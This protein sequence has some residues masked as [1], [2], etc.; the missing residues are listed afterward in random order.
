MVFIGMPG[1]PGKDAQEGT[2]RQ[3]LETVVDRDLCIGCGA[4]TAL[5]DSPFEVRMCDDG[6]F[7][8]APRP[9]A[10]LDHPGGYL[11]VCPFAS[12]YDEDQLAAVFVDASGG[13]PHPEVGS[14]RMISAGHV[15]AGTFRK[16]GSSGGMTTW[17]LDRLLDEGLVD[18][19]IHV[20]NHGPETLF[21]Y[22]VSSTREE[23]RRGAKTRY[24]PVEM[25]GVLDHVRRTEGRYAVV[26]LPCFIK[27]VRLLQ[28]EDEV[29][30]E[31]VAFAVGIFCGH[32]KST[33]FADAL[34]WQQGVA[35]GDLRAIDFRQK[36]DE[37]ALAYAVATQ[38][39]RG[40][41]RSMLN[42]RH[43]PSDWGM[44]MFRYRA[45]D[46][47]DDVLNETADVAFGDAWLPGFDEDPQG[48]NVM[49]V[50]SPEALALVA[51]RHEELE[52]SPLSADDAARSQAAGLRH[53][54]EG[55]AYRLFLA[56]SRGEW[57]PRKRVSPSADLEE[58]RRRIYDLRT[59]MLT[60]AD[61]A[62]EQGLAQGSFRAFR[63][64]VMPA[65]Q[66]YLRAYER[67]PR[68]RARGVIKRRIPWLKSARGTARAARNVLRRH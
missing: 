60:A 50:R 31:R 21:Q 47:C 34:A 18:Q 25:S 68:Q 64:A 8:A 29:F 39:A 26:G 61:R 45:C 59:E 2:A 32:L 4:C 17:F 56:D 9:D 24:Y 6:R 15:G 7:R 55:L 33:R 10:D 53:R 52:A 41:V 43:L 44:G 40:E 46:F 20:G 49:V 37:S 54:R 67:T 66:R 14:H 42:R 1:M 23:I 36:T 63:K 19:V 48:A 62:F 12:Q 57:V 51:R 27:A 13:F 58:S 28:V 65:V 16:N 22:R 38:D 3:L 30:R 35:P 5:P 11:R